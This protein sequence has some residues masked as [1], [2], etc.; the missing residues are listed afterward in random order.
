M[1]LSLMGQRKKGRGAGN[2]KIARAAA[3]RP[4]HACGLWVAYLADGGGK[5]RR[6]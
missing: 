1:T 5:G 4:A 2:Q 3:A 6:V